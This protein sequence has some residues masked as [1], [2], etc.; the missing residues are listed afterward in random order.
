MS[1]TIPTLPS[2][3]AGYIVTPDDLNAIGSAAYFLL[4]KPMALIKQISAG[5]VI[6]SSGT[7]ISYGTSTN[8]I[9]FD[10]DGMY[11]TANGDRLTIQ[12]PGWYKVSY[13]V[14]LKSTTNLASNAAVYST[15]GPNNPIGSGVTSSAFW[16]SYVNYYPGA[17]ASRGLWPFYLYEG[18]YIRVQAF[19]ASGDSGL[20]TNAS[21][22]QG[23]AG[24]GSLLGLEY[25]GVSL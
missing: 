25:V 21:D 6:S 15:S 13:T 16:A 22:V 2:I 7:Y 9:M 14:T 23:N 19:A 8:V 5:Q 18:D 10:T 24:M 4:N 3:T 11:S 1:M 20:K 17:A 12:T